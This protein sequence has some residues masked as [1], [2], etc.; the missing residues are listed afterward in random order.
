MNDL[1][2]ALEMSFELRS[3]KELLSAELPD[4]HRFSERHNSKMKDFIHS[5]QSVSYR[6]FGTK[7]RC[8]LS[9]AVI[10]LSIITLTAC[11]VAV[12]EPI[13][14]FIVS[15]FD[16]H[17]K[18]DF[19]SGDNTDKFEDIPQ[20]EEI[21]ETYELTVIPEGYV[22]ESTQSGQTYVCTYYNKNG[23][24]MF[25]G[26]YSDGIYRDVYFD[27]NSN[28]ESYYDENGLEYLIADVEEG[29][30]V[31]WNKGDYVLHL[32]G[33]FT[34]EEALELCKSAKIIED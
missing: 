34:K 1:K 12:S 17:Y 19:N 20:F 25:F 23:K 8:A 31:L 16:D 6:W 29:I 24:K 11:T 27:S 15:V 10:C 9:V 3:E 28:P 2:K 13:R 4:E 14:N 5:R 7:K 33:N 18:V 32:T 21:K 30:C 22:K 26:Q